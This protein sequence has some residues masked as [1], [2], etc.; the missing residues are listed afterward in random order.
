MGNQERNAG[1]HGGRQSCDRDDIDTG[2]EAP[3]V[4]NPFNPGDFIECLDG[5]ASACPAN[6]C[7]GYEPDGQ[8]RREQDSRSNPQRSSE[9]T[10]LTFFG[11]VT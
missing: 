11:G 2:N 10:P 9:H 3:L 4:C 6:I 1:K 8:S 7:P 5:H